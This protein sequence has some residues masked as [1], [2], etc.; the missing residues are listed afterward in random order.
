MRKTIVISGLVAAV[1]TAALAADAGAATRAQHGAKCNAAWTGK[2]GTA[3]YRAFKRHCIAASIAATKAAHDAGN[4]DDAT[5]NRGRAAAACRVEFPP[6]RRSKARRAAFKACVSAAVASQK[7]Y[8][9]RPLEATLAGSAMTDPDGSGTARLTLNQGRRQVCFDVRWTNLDTVTELHVHAVAGDGIVLAL[10]TDGNL[11]D[12]S[13]KG[14]VNGLA[15]ATI[16]ALRQHP[17]R[18]YVNVHTDVNPQG[19]IR[20]TLHK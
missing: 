2:R 15:P 18:Y 9:G 11:A 1:A 7:A 17:D 3:A 6:P 16:K 10:D 14:C 4:N 5:A 19:A 20:G 8:G 12:G 13:A